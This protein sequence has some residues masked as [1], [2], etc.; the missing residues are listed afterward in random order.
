MPIEVVY[1]GD[2]CDCPKHLNY[3]VNIPPPPK[4]KVYEPSEY[5][6]KLDVPIPARAKVTYSFDFMVEEPKKPPP[7]EESKLDLYA[8]IDRITAHKKGEF[9]QMFFFIFIR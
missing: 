9:E 7:P 2:S 3:L 6:Y 4:P 8:K 1:T 5:G